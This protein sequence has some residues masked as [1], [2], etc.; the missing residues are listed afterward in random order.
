MSHLPLWIKESGAEHSVRRP[1]GF[2]KSFRLE[3]DKE[4]LQSEFFFLK[5]EAF[6]GETTGQY[7]AS[8][9]KFKTAYKWLKSFYVNW[10]IRWAGLRLPRPL[11]PGKTI[12]KIWWNN[13]VNN[14]TWRH[15][16]S[17]HQGP[18]SHQSPSCPHIIEEWYTRGV[19]YII[20]GMELLKT[21]LFLRLGA[22]AAY[23][24]CIL[25]S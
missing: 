25:I 2:G 7:N 21:H 16:A 6:T 18:C 13:C 14:K 12:D 8:R 3:E 23:G 10:N 22:L 17:T 9:L 20:I 1:I 24:Y 4:V 11:W 5:A 19:S 15:T